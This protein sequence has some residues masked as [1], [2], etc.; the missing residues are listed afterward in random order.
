MPHELT[1]FEEKFLSKLAFVLLNAIMFTGEYQAIMNRLNPKEKVQLFQQLPEIKMPERAKEKIRE[2]LKQSIKQDTAPK[3]IPV[4]KSDPFSDKVA[5]MLVKRE[6]KYPRMYKDIYG[7]PT[8]GIGHLVKPNEIAKYKNAVLTPHEM[9]T[10]MYTDINEKLTL[11]RR[12]FP[13]FD[14]YPEKL[15]MLIV[16]GYFRGD[17]SGSPATK[18]LIRMGKFKQAA[19]EYLDNV[20]YRKSVKAG[21]GVAKRMRQN[22]LV[23]KSL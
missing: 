16:D 6:G 4:A 13:K 19:D 22:A 14:S 17:L 8:I 1:I 7:H 21:T 11:V 20:E 5:D 3:V 15:K 23:L 12:D 9:Y 2:V 10:L 18:R